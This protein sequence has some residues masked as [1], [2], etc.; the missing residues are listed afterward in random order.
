MNTCV[1]VS[2]C[3]CVLHIHLCSMC[4]YDCVHKALSSSV[5]T[6]CVQTSVQTVDSPRLNLFGCQH[7]FFSPLN[8]RK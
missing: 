6:V 4:I 2:E 7:L 3:E 1:N 5:L 8:S